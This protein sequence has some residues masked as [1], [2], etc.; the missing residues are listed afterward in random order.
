METLM[1]KLPRLFRAVVPN[2]PV[3]LLLAALLGTL[4]APVVAAPV[5][6]NVVDPA[7]KPV[8]GATV[9]VFGASTVDTPEIS[10][11]DADGKFTVELPPGYSVDSPNGRACMV[12]A[13]GFAPCGA[14]LAANGDNRI[15]VLRPV[16]VSGT[17]TD[18]SGQPV[19]G[20]EVSAV[21]AEIGSALRGSWFSFG[22][23]RS[24]YTVKTDAQGT[25]SIPNLPENSVVD[26]KLDDPSY[27]QAT[28]ATSRGSL[29]APPITAEAGTFITG[30]VVREDGKPA[31]ALTVQAMRAGND[32]GRGAGTT[33]ADGTFNIAGLAAGTYSLLVTGTAND[34]TLPDW[35]SPAPVTVAASIEKPG[36]APDIVLIRGALVTGRVVDA[37]TKKAVAG[38]DLFVRESS[39]PRGRWARSVTGADGTFK[40]R[41]WPGTSELYV[42][43]VPAGYANDT[44]QTKREVTVSEDHPLAVDTIALSHGLV[45]TGKVVREDG[46]PTGVLSID[47]VHR[48]SAN[49]TQGM[50]NTATAPDGTY[51]ITGLL[52]GT[53][54]ISLGAPG[55]ESTIPDFAAPSPVT[56][57]VTGNMPAIVPDLVL[58]PGALVTGLIVDSDTGKPVPGVSIGVQNAV[59][60]GYS[61]RSANA[62]TDKDG[63]YTVRAWAGHLALYVYTVPKEY[64]VASPIVAHYFNVTEGQPLTL[65]PITITPGL[66]VVGTAVDEAGAPV[67]D[68]TL[69][70]QRVQDGG[71]SSDQSVTTDK[72]GTFTI[73][74][75]VP[76][77][78]FVDPGGSWIVELP[79]TFTVPSTA[80]IK[81]TL[82][83]AATT[84]LHG[85]VADTSGAPVAGANLTF[86]PLHMLPNGSETGSP[87]SATTD[88]SGSF[89]LPEVPADANMI[90][91]PTIERDGYVFKS[92][93]DI[94][95][96]GNQLSI[97]PIIMDRLGGVVTGVVRN[98]MNAPVPGAWVG[99]PSGSGDV[100]PVKAD[101]T[102][103][104]KFSNLVLGPVDVYAAKGGYFGT[105][106][107]VAAM[108][109]ASMSITLKPLPAP[110]LPSNMA[111]ATGMLDNA[112][113]SAVSAEGA[114]PSWWMR[115]ECAQVLA[116][117]SHDA[118]LQF[119]RL[120][121]MPN[122]GD[123][124][125]IIPVQC[126]LNPAGAAKWGVDLVTNTKDNGYVGAV[127]VSLGLAI[128]AYDK[129]AA[130]E[131]Y[132]LASQH[133]ALGK[134]SQ[135]NVQDAMKLAGL[136]YALD[137]PEADACY[138]EVLA[139]VKRD[140]A[141][142][143]AN[144][145]EEWQMSQ[146]A[147][148]VALGNVKL[149][150]TMLADMSLNVRLNTTPEIVRELVQR[151]PSGAL[152]VFHTLDADADSSSWAYDTAL[153][154]V[155]PIIFTTD[156][157]GAFALA[158]GVADP[159]G[160]AE[161]IALLADLMPLAQA[162]ALYE[163]AESEAGDSNSSATPGGTPESIAAHALLRDRALGEE[164]FKQA[165]DKI[166]AAQPAAQAW[167]GPS[168]A[169]FAFYYGRVDPGY[170]RVLLEN[171]FRK[172]LT[173]PA[174][175]YGE[176]S[177]LLCDVAAMSSIDAGRASELANRIED[178]NM[179][180]TAD[181]KI[182]QYLVEGKR[183]RD[184]LPFMR[185]SSDE[186]WTPESPS[187]W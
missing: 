153:D 25:Y 13:K 65:D 45:A 2:V 38:V 142:P 51:K 131:M 163:E 117:V 39:G 149:A 96:H 130:N 61:V 91:R 156:P 98:G 78:Y 140:I 30:K 138:H 47:V 9:Y 175:N 26:I 1:S 162:K 56:I 100:R 34:A 113:T 35:A 134:L 84:T 139:E 154:Y 70:P 112:L 183:T 69:R 44:A 167:Q 124:Q 79:K 182:A 16:T 29:T 92:G 20:A 21:F 168:Y 174:R 60:P 5:T 181:L 68:V 46:K 36:T 177:G 180:F 184:T 62:T 114:E 136:A 54:S 157:K 133:V 85:S 185:W 141:S 128:A 135:T 165:F 33:K 104:F 7:G 14:V 158:K 24:R 94:T 173:D 120:R 49:E 72:N 19:P 67:P 63:R 8:G 103:H 123:L 4:S 31:G 148:N 40:M 27:V 137:R 132:D 17:V 86:V 71:W 23:L 11:T 81:V 57:T 77:T 166:T 83:K 74:Q 143:T 22:P 76:G 42:S 10:A 53:Y 125:C 121:A 171:L 146:F 176:G 41:V 89:S 48:V 106:N 3:F 122:T 37:Q 127:A 152:D 87:I 164:L 111:G 179:R 187:S 66:T 129:A 150:K 64:T 169:E 186:D 108:S 160:R 93:G 101:A 109:P 161:A 43:D 119:V 110:P 80:P 118:A 12:D 145:G 82:K 144:G 95:G 151:N 102:G 99:C 155:L 126:A 28:V 170:S 58:S 147:E 73:R 97:S 90:E 50:A 75:L 115:D 172:D 59:L 6:C 55:G 52:P 107:V 178:A 15:Q 116:E 18:S 32:P 105:A 88:G 159:N